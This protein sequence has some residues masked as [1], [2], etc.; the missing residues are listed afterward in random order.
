MSGC[1]SL[2]YRESSGW[3]REPRPAL[4]V[5]KSLRSSSHSLYLE[6]KERKEQDEDL[7]VRCRLQET[8]ESVSV[9]MYTIPRQVMQ[10]TACLSSHADPL[11]CSRVL[12]TTGQHLL[13]L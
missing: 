6:L 2:R 4:L 10:L 8:R 11:Y 13:L 5:Y 12:L 3:R 1:T 7:M 9:K